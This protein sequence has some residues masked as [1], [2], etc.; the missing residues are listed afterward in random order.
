MPDIDSKTRDQLL[1]HQFVA[2]LPISV[3][4]LLRAAGAVTDLLEAIKRAKLLMSLE[5][6]LPTL[7]AAIDQHTPFSDQIARLTDQVR[8]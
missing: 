6:A 7:T 3:S 4:K 5:A 8:R 1:L 2:G